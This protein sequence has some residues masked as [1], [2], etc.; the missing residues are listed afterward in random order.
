[1]AQKRGLRLARIPYRLS[2]D[3]IETEITN[4]VVGFSSLAN[5]PDAYEEAIRKTP[6]NR[7]DLLQ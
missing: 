5:V 4:I 3:E 6:S 1:L 7:D 2:D